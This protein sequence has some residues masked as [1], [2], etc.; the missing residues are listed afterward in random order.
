MPPAASADS[1]ASS[2]SFVSSGK[3]NQARGEATTMSANVRE[4]M[5]EAMQ[6]DFSAVSIHR[7]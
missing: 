6:A 3:L 4:R 7:K 5:E 2:T 1:K